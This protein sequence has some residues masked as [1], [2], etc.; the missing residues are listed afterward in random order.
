MV[1]NCGHRNDS[2][3]LYLRQCVAEVL[4][5]RPVIF[6]NRLSMKSIPNRRRYIRSGV[7]KTM[8]AFCETLVA[9][10]GPSQI[11][12]AWS[13]PTDLGSVVIPLMITIT[14]IMI[15]IMYN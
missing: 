9:K 3:E 2:R 7:K 4:S 14:L 10:A 11:S 6:G 13:R 15:I 5:L 1:V 8:A 12:A